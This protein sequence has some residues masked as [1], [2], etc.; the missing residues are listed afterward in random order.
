MRH[1]LSN[2]A[3]PPRDA[4]TQPDQPSRDAADSAERGS[5]ITPIA[6][7]VAERVVR[8]WWAVVVLAVLVTPAI[9]PVV[10]PMA[11]RQ[12]VAIQLADVAVGT[13]G[14]FAVWD[15]QADAARVVPRGRHETF[16]TE[17]ALPG[18]VESVALAGPTARGRV[19]SAS[20]TTSVFGIDAG[21]RPVRSIDS[22]TITPDSGATLAW[23]SWGGA[24]GVLTL[25][26]VGG[27]LGLGAVFACLVARRGAS[28][29]GVTI[30]AW[31][32]VFAV[33]AWMWLVAPMVFTKDGVAYLDIAQAL[34]DGGGLAALDP[35]R[36][37]G[38]GLLLAPFIGID[39]PLRWTFG[40]LNVL[41][42]LAIVWCAW[43]IARR[44]AGNA[45]A[46][47]A[48]VL[49]GL[50]PF[51]LGFS[52]TVG[53]EIPA[54]ACA[55]AA[56]WLVACRP[57][58]DRWRGDVLCAIALGVLLG[59]AALMRANLQVLLVLMPVCVGWLVAM[60]GVG[61]GGWR[62]ALPAGLARGAVVGAVALGVG[63]MC[64]M[65]VVLHNGRTRGGYA[66]S[67]FGNTT[68]FTSLLQ[69]GVVEPSD[70]G[71]LDAE[72]Y[73]AVRDGIAGNSIAFRYEMLALAGAGEGMAEVERVAGEVVARTT[74]RDLAGVAGTAL[75]ALGVQLG[76]VPAERVMRTSH[77]WTVL[78]PR[79][80]EL[81]RGTPTNFMD[82]QRARTRL[83]DA[84]VDAN[85]RS[86]RPWRR[87]VTADL[88]AGLWNGWS[89]LRPVVGVLALVGGVCLLVRG[90]EG[91]V[92][93]LGVAL[94]HACALALV[95]YTPIERY[96]FP[97][98]PIV[99]VASLACFAA[100]RG[101]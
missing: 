91:P 49:V 82:E 56:A 21:T 19:A 39:A 96:Q 101:R 15:G 10:R 74:Q 57:W 63:V 66:L 72:A 43:R 83:G 95:A 76:I 84:V 51:L 86:L 58:G 26:G 25:A 52:R 68:K 7:A 99:V 46:V 78:R 4:V 40:T 89:V 90:R 62:P 17:L 29:Q 55:C 97:V 75:A 30:A 6:R 37:A 23:M 48:I 35:I 60:R 1:D 59:C 24:I 20:V 5:I 36:P 8:R 34:A 53:T 9:W 70:A 61:D 41:L 3:D 2:T 88:Y 80:G 64:V 79:A 94:A 45:V 16:D 32:I 87:G 92:L 69:T 18:R 98:W 93:V 33:H 47:A 13:G 100:R 71:P 50:D 22:A 12:T 27:V 73:A 85:L 65:P 42:A 77:S 44:A 11:V 31:A 67:L 28:V 54:C 38:I 14:L 81:W